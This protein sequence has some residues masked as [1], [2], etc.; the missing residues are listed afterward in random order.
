M[1]NF[2]LGN[3]MS[4]SPFLFSIFANDPSQSLGTG[5]ALSMDLVEM[6]VLLPSI[7]F[8]SFFLVMVP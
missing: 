4:N 8:V 2:F 5:H 3:L 6:L 7:V 1:I